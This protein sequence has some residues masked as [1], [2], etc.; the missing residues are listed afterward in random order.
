LTHAEN[1][2]RIFIHL[3]LTIFVS[4]LIYLALRASLAM[5]NGELKFPDLATTVAEKE[6]GTSRP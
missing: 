3:I 5:E 2:N 6:D 1:L 4:G